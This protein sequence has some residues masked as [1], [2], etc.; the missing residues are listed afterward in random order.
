MI[1]DLYEVELSDKAV[2]NLNE[3]SAEIAIRI[4]RKVD[5]YL[6]QSPYEL[7]KPLSHRYKGLYRYRYGDYR[8]VYEIIESKR[9]IVVIPI[10]RVMYH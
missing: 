4:K 7:G 9:T 5:S 1:E 2:D 6:A 3:L 10:T 8:I